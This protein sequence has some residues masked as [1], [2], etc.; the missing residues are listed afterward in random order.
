MS[1]EKEYGCS[2]CPL[3]EGQSCNDFDAFGTIAC[4]ICGTINRA[5]VRGRSMNPISCNV[6]KYE[7]LQSR[8]C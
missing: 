4:G 2:T 5:V 7:S 3:K 1:G 6:K 8:C